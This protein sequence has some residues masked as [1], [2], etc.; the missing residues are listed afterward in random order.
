MRDY[1]RESEKDKPTLTDKHT[2]SDDAFAIVEALY[3]ILKE[4][5]RN[6]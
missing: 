2:L 6:G 3:E 4:M 5:K 1:K